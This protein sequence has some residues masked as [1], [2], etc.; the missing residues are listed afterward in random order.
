M[1]LSKT[2][3]VLAAIVFAFDVLF[4]LFLFVA[5]S[6]TSDVASGHTVPLNF[7]RG[8]VLY[9]SPLEYGIFVGSLVTAGVLFLLGVFVYTRV[10]RAAGDQIE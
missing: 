1:L 10:T 7:Y 9:L 8:F 2:C 3:V 5:A 6:R 4:S